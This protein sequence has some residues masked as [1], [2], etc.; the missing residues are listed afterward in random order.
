MCHLTKALL[1]SCK[2]IIC[3]TDDLIETTN[4]KGE[5]EWRNLELG[6]KELVDPNGAFMRCKNSDVS[7]G[8]MIMAYTGLTSQADIIRICPLYLSYIA[9]QKWTGASE[10]NP[11]YTFLLSTRKKRKLGCMGQMLITIILV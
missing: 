4:A 2:I 8:R 7:Q 10:V 9:K 11:K 6:F 1:T 5:K 3:G